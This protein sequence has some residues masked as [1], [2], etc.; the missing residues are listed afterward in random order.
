M[1]LVMQSD[2]VMSK[3]E[4]VKFQKFNYLW[5]NQNSHRLCNMNINFQLN[6]YFILINFF[7]ICLSLNFWKIDRDAHI[8]INFQNLKPDFA[9]QYYAMTDSQPGYYGIPYDLSS[10]MHYGSGGGTIRALDQNRNFL[11]GQRNG[12][13]FLDIQMANIAYKCDGIIN[14]LIKFCS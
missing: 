10:I 11:M 9:P 2:F 14:I 4:V 7:I 1:N 3:V 8:R 5:I 12:L 13:S 6:F